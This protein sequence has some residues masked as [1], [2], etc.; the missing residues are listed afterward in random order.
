MSPEK[1]KIAVDSDFPK[2]DES[3]MKAAAKDDTVGWNL[4]VNFCI[5][6]ISILKEKKPL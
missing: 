5:L 3:F 6:Q 1:S 4:A 2:P